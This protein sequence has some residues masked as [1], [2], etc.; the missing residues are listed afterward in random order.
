MAVI[1]HFVWQVKRK[2][3]GLPVEHHLM[4]ILVGKS[5]GGKSVAVQKLIDPLTEVASYR[6][7]TIFNDQFA[8][9]AF[10]RNFVIFFDE[11]GRLENTDVNALKSIITAPRVEWRGMGSEASHSARQNATFIGCSNVALRDRLQ[12]PSSVRRFWEL[13]CQDRLNW[14]TVNAIDYTALWRSVD[15]S[16]PCPILPVIDQIRATQESTLRQRDHAERWLDATCEP[17]TFS[18]ASPTTEQ[19]HRAFIGWCQAQGIFDVDGLQTFARA[20]P[21]RVMNLGWSVSSKRSYRGT[22]WSLG[23]RSETTPD[24]DPDAVET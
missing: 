2:L 12:D 6:D 20:L 23:V 18:D 10:A 19:L 24:H 7:M 15:E 5:G 13:R 11:L 14:A 9:R 17:R 21:L 22:T 4:A 8:R 3:F 16:S 1:R